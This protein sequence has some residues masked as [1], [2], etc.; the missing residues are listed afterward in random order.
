[1]VDKGRFSK[2]CDIDSSQGCMWTGK[3]VELLQVS[4]LANAGEVEVRELF[5]FGICHFPVVFSSK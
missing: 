3:S 4:F 1:M 2:I 5:F